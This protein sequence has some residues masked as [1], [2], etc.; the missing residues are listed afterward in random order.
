MHCSILDVAAR[1]KDLSNDLIDLPVSLLRF[2]H[3][4][5]V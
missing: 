2:E 5:K 3:Y 1:V 4:C